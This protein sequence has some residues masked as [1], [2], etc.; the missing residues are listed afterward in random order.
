ME[1]K[2]VTLK[3]EKIIVLSTPALARLWRQLCPCGGDKGKEKG[4]KIPDDQELSRQGVQQE[5][6]S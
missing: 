6:G 4:K 2:I 1:L 3:Y 5:E